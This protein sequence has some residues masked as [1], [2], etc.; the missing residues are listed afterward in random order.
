MK[1]V[2]TKSSEKELLALDRKTAQRVFRKIELFSKNPLGNKAKRLSGSKGYRIRV[3]DYR[4][5]YLIDR[6]IKEI[7]IIKIGHRR[8]VYK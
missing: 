2:Y 7:V 6:K 4:V 5:I 8:E 3:G 1:I